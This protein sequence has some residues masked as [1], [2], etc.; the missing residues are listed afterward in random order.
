[1]WWFQQGLCFLPAAQIIWTA[2]SFVFAYITAVV[3]NHVDPLL[4]YIRFA[5]HLLG[6]HTRGSGSFSSNTFA[7]LH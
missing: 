5:Q 2:A 1:M 7:L 3:L 4:P 6:R